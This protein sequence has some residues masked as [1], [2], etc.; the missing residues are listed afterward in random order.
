MKIYISVDLEGISGTSHWDECDKKHPDNLE[1][2]EQMTA[3]VAGACEGAL[4]AGAREIVVKDAHDSGRNLIVSRLPSEVRLMRGWSGHPYT[5]VEGIDGTFR[6]ML[7]VGYH[8]RAGSDASPLAHTRSLGLAQV[9]INGSLASEFLI[10]TY[11]ASLVSVPVAFLSGDAG[12]CREA[13]MLIPGLTTVAVKEGLGNAT[14]SIHPHLAVSRIRDSVRRSLEGDVENC[15]VRLPKRFA[16]EIGY[17]EHARAYRASF[18]PGVHL[19]DPTTIHYE[20][21]DYLE[22]LRLLLFVI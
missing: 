10:N 16:V 7:M 13:V 17:R 18:Y 9:K 20:C 8:S 2:R 6:A 15:L 19:V 14:T 21:E 12:I 3:E 1:F 22:V 5:M 4:E 11:A